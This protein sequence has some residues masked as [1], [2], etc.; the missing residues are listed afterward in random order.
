[1]NDLKEMETKMNLDSIEQE[2]TEKFKEIGKFEVKN[3][4]LNDL[5]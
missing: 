5:N 1:M 3:K 4:A 2:T